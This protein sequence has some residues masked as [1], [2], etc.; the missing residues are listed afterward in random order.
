MTPTPVLTPVSIFPSVT[1]SS[2]NSLE[3]K[4]SQTN[5]L[6]SKRSYSESNNNN[7]NSNAGVNSRNNECNSKI[8]IYES[9]K[10]TGKYYI[11]DPKTNAAVWIEIISKLAHNNDN[12]VHVNTMFN[13]NSNVDNFYFIDPKNNLKVEILKAH[14]I[15]K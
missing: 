9:K 4:E 12:N 7:N 10:Y 3:N 11:T 14:F 1:S 5:Q 15:P 2:H 6:N 13:M 8:E